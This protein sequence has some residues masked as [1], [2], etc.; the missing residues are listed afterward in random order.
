MV[1]Q[2][3]DTDGSQSPFF[4]YPL[5]RSPVQVSMEN[6]SFKQ[7]QPKLCGFREQLLT[8]RL[9]AMVYH[10]LTHTATCGNFTALLLEYL[11]NE[12]AVSL[13]RNIVKGS[14]REPLEM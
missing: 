14:R 7:T 10:A 5:F 11:A 9:H 2:H 1:N 8:W 6:G 4:K 12:L 3:S 13:R